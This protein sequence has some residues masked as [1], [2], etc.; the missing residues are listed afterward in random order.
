MMRPTAAS[1]SKTH[2]KPSSPPHK[3]TKAP[4]SAL[5]KGKKKVE[6][7]AAKAKDAVTTN[8]HHD[9]ETNGNDAHADDDASKASD[10]HAT[11]ADAGAQEDTMKTAAPVQEPEAPTAEAQT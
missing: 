6:E 11:D 7:V 8:G 4:V 5:Q 9:E 10:A 2:D 1:A 3:S